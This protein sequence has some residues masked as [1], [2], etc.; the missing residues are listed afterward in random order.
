MNGL[1]QFHITTRTIALYGL[2]LGAFHS[3]AGA[4]SGHFRAV[5]AAAGMLKSVCVTYL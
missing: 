4:I 3:A 1:V 2:E 5:Q